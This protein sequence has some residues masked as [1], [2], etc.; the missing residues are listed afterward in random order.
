MRLLKL[1]LKI[2]NQNSNTMEIEGTITKNFGIIT[3]TSA[4]GNTWKKLEFLVEQFGQ[5]PK[6]A[7]IQV[8]GDKAET[9]VNDAQVGRQVTVS[10]SVESREY[11]ERYFTQLT[12]W[13]IA[14]YV[15]LSERYNNG[16]PAQRQSAAQQTPPVTPPVGTNTG[17]GI[18][19]E[20][21]GD[22]LPF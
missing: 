11:N 21:D 12:A 8:M 14:G 22:D 15:P 2:G 7:L 10:V 5:Y 4:N 18:T 6:N 9:M 17:T 20:D 3:G 16:Q 19:A 1:S 13:R